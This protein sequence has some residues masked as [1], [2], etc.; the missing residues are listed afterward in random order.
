MLRSI[1]DAYRHFEHKA[2]L[3]SVFKNSILSQEQQSPLGSPVA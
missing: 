3:N 1:L 2:S